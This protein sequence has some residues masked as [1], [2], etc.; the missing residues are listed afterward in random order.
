MS[1]IIKTHLN[2]L[3]SP[4]LSVISLVLW[5][6]I[7]VLFAA[8]RVKLL[9]LHCLLNRDGGHT[10]TSAPVLTRKCVFDVRL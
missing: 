10:L 1:T 3:C 5:V 4:K 8:W 6:Q 7:E 2:D 9:D